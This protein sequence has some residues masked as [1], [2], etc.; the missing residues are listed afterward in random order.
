MA[1]PLLRLE[2]VYKSFGSV[3][4][5]AGVDLEVHSATIHG[6]IG[7]NGAGKST[8]MKVLSGV[9][10]PDS[11]RMILDGKP[12][13]P[14]SPLDGRTAGISM[15]YQELVLAPHLTVEEN[16]TLGAEKSSLGWV[17]P[18]TD[19]VREVLA[20]LDQ[21][22]DPH[23][24][25]RKLSIGKQQLVEI[26]RALLLQSRVVVMDEP[27]S[28]L[29]A[30]DARALFKVIR[31]L[32]ARGVAVIYI[33]H[34]LEEVEEICE[35]YTVI[36]D[37][38]TVSSG[39]V[40][41]TSISQIIKDMV[42]RSVD[43]LFP[44]SDHIV[45]EP[46]LRVSGL[47]GRDGYPDG[48]SFVLHRS[49]ILG[50][51]G[52][53]G[54][55]R[56]ETVRSLFGLHRASDGTVSIEGRPDLSA[57]HVGPGDALNHGFDLL[58]EDRKLE[59]LALNMSVLDNLTLSDLSRYARAG[60]LN[61][62]KERAEGMRWIDAL[63]VRCR[64]PSQKVQELSGG[65]QQKACVAR[66]LHQDNDILFLDEPT[67]GIDIGSKAEIYRLIH[68]L[69]RRG[70]AI[71]MISSYLPEL[72]GMCDTLAVMFRGEMS[73]ARPV[74]EWTETSIMRFATSGVYELDPME[75]D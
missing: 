56:S 23:M 6:L 59:G 38:R 58:S 20:W 7:E 28:S 44:E 48:V 1:D 36:R 27:T 42:G 3:Q 65:N 74:D 68:E 54:S 40:A 15:I 66:L 51:A 57:A 30:S 75:T 29:S 71:V 39:W 24:P 31:R 19:E 69:S 17:T 70:K 4:A 49:E 26:A 64:D 53:V 45:G 67:R 32:K 16:V 72:R 63:G 9:H 5:L 10:Q 8:L 60:F 73:P 33:S 52:L 37:G 11:G 62:R 41:D 46:L 25:V 2:N 13:A 61:L 47:R 35:A 22:I 18:R 50:I 43:E 34:F 14:Q 12:F 21:D 55:G